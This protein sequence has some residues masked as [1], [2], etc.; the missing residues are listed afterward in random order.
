MAFNTID[1]DLLE[2][3]N[4]DY[5]LDLGC[6]VGRHSL[7]AYR[8]YPVNVF[9]V[10]LSLVDLR[11]AKSREKD[12]QENPCQGSLLFLQSDGYKL[13]F[14]DKSFDVVICS[15]VLEHVPSYQQ[16]I[17]EL[18]RVLKPGGRL[19]LS[20]PKYLPEKICWLLSNDYPE[21]AGHVRIFKGSQLEKAVIK[22]G[23]SLTNKHSAHALHSPYWW[24][25]S[26]FFERGES[27]LPA[28]KYK[29]LMDWQLLKGGE[30][31]EKLEALFNPVLGK[32]NVY[33]FEK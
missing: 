21:F 13:P 7:I 32:S 33:Y 26:L 11:L 28:R 9:G 30:W 6:G 24:L 19:A 5:V 3:K 12:I 16:L 4:N 23:L 25:R 2:L 18:V 20:V 17:A 15:E 22:E 14:N 1:F 10:D 31:T 8:D 27:F 29:D